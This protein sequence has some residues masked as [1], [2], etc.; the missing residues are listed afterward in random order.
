MVHSKV[1]LDTDGGDLNILLN[2]YPRL[3]TK[4][5]HGHTILLCSS[6]NV[7]RSLVHKT[8][9]STPQKVSNFAASIAIFPLFL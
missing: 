1:S 5:E 2:A 7:S 9:K 3:L 4:Q 8:P 6:T